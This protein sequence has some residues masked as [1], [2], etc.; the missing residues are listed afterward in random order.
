MK[1]QAT[2]GIDDDGVV[3]M[4]RVAA[5]RLH[6]KGHVGEPMSGGGL[7]L[8][9]I[10]AAH[11]MHAGRL[12]IDDSTWHDLLADRR[13]ESRYWAYADLR[14]RGLVVRHDGDS[15]LAWQRGDAPPS[16]PWFRLI[17]VA[18]RDAVDVGLLQDAHG[19]VVGVVD[20]DGAV[21]YYRVD[22]ESP[23]GEVPWP[24]GGP[25]AANILGD[26]VVVPG[27]AGDA[28][29]MGTGHGDDLVLSITEAAALAQRGWLRV[30]GEA[31]GAAAM[32]Q[33]DYGRTLP[34]YT[35]LRNVGVLPK[36]GFRFGT[37][38]RAYSKGVDEGHAEWLIQCHHRSDA[39]HWS[40]LSRAVRLAHGVRKT[41][42]LAVAEPVSFH[43]ISWFRP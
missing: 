30:D 9:H 29:G 42:L 33:A 40:Q 34:V 16:E 10:E 17:A 21:T 22:D 2:G 20:E 28:Q 38:L 37:H 6:K 4:D 18:E 12:R 19:C 8:S 39:P 14:D 41:F 36:S 15:F 31:I 27:A 43:A 25:H 11:A 1:G 26:R 32:E 3:V 24:R 23:S 5:D 13:D 35:A 7:R